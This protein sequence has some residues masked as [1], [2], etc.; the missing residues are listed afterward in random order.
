M[1]ILFFSSSVLTDL[2]LHQHPASPFF[3]F[4]LPLF[5]SSGPQATALT[6][7]HIL[8][9][10][11]SIFL[12]HSSPLPFSYRR[13]QNF[14]LFYPSFLFSSSFSLAKTDLHSRA[15]I[16]KRLRSPGI[17]Y[18]ESIPPVYVAWRADTS[19][20]V[21]VPARQAGN[22]FLGSLKGLQIRA[23]YVLVQRCIFA[24]LIHVGVGGGGA[25]G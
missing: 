17:D 11:S 9:S 10:L 21:V 5:H 13:H 6:D 4:S 25:L 16:C 23:L 2:R 20:R 19:N 15:R 14:I 7:I 8:F 12:F 22:R 18:K 3:Y 24:H 1:Q